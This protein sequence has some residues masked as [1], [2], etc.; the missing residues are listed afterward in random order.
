[1]RHFILYISV[2]LKPMVLK[3]TIIRCNDIGPTHMKCLE[4]IPLWKWYNGIPATSKRMVQGVFALSFQNDH[5]ASNVRNN[6]TANFSLLTVENQDRVF[7]K[8]SSNSWGYFDNKNWSPSL[9]KCYTKAIGMIVVPIASGCYGAD[10]LSILISFS[11][12]WYCLKIDGANSNNKGAYIQTWF[13]LLVSGQQLLYLLKSSF[14]LACCLQNQCN[15][16]VIS[17]KIFNEILGRQSRIVLD[18]L[19]NCFSIHFA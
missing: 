14:F 6:I 12:E 1:M 5:C 10:L 4:N 9:L 11:Q 7:V 8:S 17:I 13:P 15:I 18:C 16:S 3:F 2:K 19:N